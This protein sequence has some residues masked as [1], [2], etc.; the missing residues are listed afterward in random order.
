[1]AYEDGNAERPGLAAGQAIRGSLRMFFTY[2]G[3]FFWKMRAGMGDIVFA[4]FYEVLKRRGVKF[5]FFHRLENLRLVDA[6]DLEAGER[7]YVSALEF[8]V[9][10]Q[11][12]QPDSSGDDGETEYQPLTDIR[13]LPCWSATPDFEQLVGGDRLQS[14][15]WQFE[16]FWDRNKVA[17]K[18]LE[19]GK[20]FDFVVLGIGIG[21]IPYVCADILERDQRWREMVE[22]V[23]TVPSQAFQVWMSASMKDLGWNAPPITLSAFSKPFDTWADMGHLIEMESWDRQPASIAY[24]CSVLKDQP[25]DRKDCDQP[26]K[27]RAEVRE[28]AIRFLNEEIQHLWPNAK[29]DGGGFRWEIL[30]DPNVATA[31]SGSRDES[32]FDTQFWTANINPSDRYTLALPGSLKYRISPLDNTYDNLTIAGDWTE[33]GFNEGCVEAAV[34][35]G[36]LAAHALCKTPHLH[37]IIGYDH[38]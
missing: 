3:A 18:T 16:S 38:P 8:D 2:R 25:I 30:V 11:I 35:S 14:E 15:G 27:R 4:P 21:A 23:K 10:A 19:L 29:R 6:A 31:P 36:R 33:C 32:S 22:H 26:R 5:Q 7:P 34:M 24:F 13:G 9:Q 12:R 37:D 17:N 1:M 28:N 20:D